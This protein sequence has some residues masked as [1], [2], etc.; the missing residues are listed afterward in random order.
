MMAP[1]TTRRRPR[2]RRDAATNATSEAES[3]PA[4]I[5]ARSASWRAPQRPSGAR[6]SRSQSV[7]AAVSE[8]LVTPYGLRT[9]TPE[10]P[11]YCAH[12]AGSQEARDGAYH[13][14]TVWPWLIGHY[15]TAALKCA[16]DAA[17]TAAELTQTFAPIFE[18]HLGEY[19]V[20]SIAE[21]FDG[22]PPHSPNGCIAQ[23]WSVAELLRANVSLQRSLHPHPQ[24]PMHTQRNKQGA[25]AEAG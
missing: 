20:G 11:A 6:R 9:L 5:S 4:G 23:A 19:G 15:V 16:A 13:Q 25:T 8:H 17:A 2:A 7:V 12:Y 14:G 10:S 3:S 24:N 22:S 1:R 21:I 18:K